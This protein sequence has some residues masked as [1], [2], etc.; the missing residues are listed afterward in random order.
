MP[1]DS[2]VELASSCESV[3][4]INLKTVGSN[5]HLAVA[6]LPPREIGGTV[7]EAMYL[8]DKKRH[9]PAGTMLS[10]GQVDAREAAGILYDEVRKQVR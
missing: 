9:E 6:F 2:T 7:S 10:E 1:Y 3:V 4:I 8:G 5:A